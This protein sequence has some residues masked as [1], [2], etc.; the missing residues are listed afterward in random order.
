MTSEPLVSVVT[1]VYNGESYLKE[2]VES[3]LRQTYSNWEY[4]IV[5]NCSTDA[6]AKI[7]KEFA[8]RESRVRVLSNEKLLPIIANH[9]RA[10]RAISAASKYC[11]VVSADDWIFPECLAKMVGLAEAHPGVGIIGSYQLSGGGDKWYVRT[12]GL[13]YDCSVVSGRE[14]C[15]AHLLTD[16][17]VFGNPTSNLYRSDLVRAS[18][19]FFPN[20][21]AEA[22]VSACF[23]QLKSA[24]FGFVHQVLSYERL[25]E[26]RV[27]TLSED[28]NAYSPSKISDL[29]QYGPFYLS[30]TEVERRLKERLDDYYEYL[31][32]C[33]VHF[34]DKRFWTYHSRRLAELGY[35]LSIKK[36]A[37]AV[38]AKLLDLSLNPKRT[39]EALVRALKPEGKGDSW[40]LCES[41]RHIR[42]DASMSGVIHGTSSDA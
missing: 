36:L 22:D 11:K 2:C 35:P 21:T 41:L 1:P 28:M 19:A 32:I 12:D 14:I 17:S 34:R 27:T 31:A 20:A 15:R 16:L 9:N 25:H 3:V 5:N 7:A 37:K 6:T 40:R 4:I 29:L 39:V 18:D 8:D 30:K 10:F 42:G 33:A 13:P 38:C 24:D 26:V 23:K